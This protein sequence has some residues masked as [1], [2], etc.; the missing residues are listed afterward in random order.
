MWVGIFVLFEVQ[1]EDPIYRT[2]RH[3][4]HKQKDNF[5]STQD[6]QR[7]MVGQKVPG[8]LMTTKTNFRIQKKKKIKQNK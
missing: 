8:E 1:K 6:K 4:L 5:N 3:H 2:Q 7:D